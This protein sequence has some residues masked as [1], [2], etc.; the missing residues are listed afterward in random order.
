M[1]RIICSNFIMLSLLSGCMKLDDPEQIA[2]AYDIR[3][4]CWAAAEKKYPEKLKKLQKSQ[5]IY[6]TVVVGDPI[7][8]TKTIRK[9]HVVPG[10]GVR[11]FKDVTTCK[12]QTEKRYSHTKFW[13]EVID[14]NKSKRSKQ[15][16]LCIA[17]RC[18]KDLLDEASKCENTAEL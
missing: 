13:E 9:P 4:T 11:H 12:N 10:L 15:A 18:A 8:K 5:P 2:I 17:S 1:Y 3:D 16:N 14:Q 7:C 6:E